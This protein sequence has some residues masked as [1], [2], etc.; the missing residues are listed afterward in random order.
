MR[1]YSKDLRERIIK[2]L[3][4]G[5]KIKTVATRFSVSLYWVYALLRRYRKTGSYEA[6]P[7]RGG[8]PSKLREADLQRLSELVHAH[9][10]A[11]LQELKDMGGF[12]VSL[13]T[14]CRALNDKLKLV[15]KKNFSCRRAG[16][17]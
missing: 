13:P 6:L 7:N 1:A 3:E 8:A 15:R 5:E 2:A 9:P 10:D 14:I 4:I 17:P 11:T 12:S 16:T